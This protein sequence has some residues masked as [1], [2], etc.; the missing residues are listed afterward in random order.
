MVQF[1]HFLKTKFPILLKIKYAIRALIYGTTIP[2]F[3]TN[4]VDHLCVEHNEK[5]AAIEDDL[6][7]TYGRMPL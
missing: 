7:R 4:I 5:T 1:K 6:M 2:Y 3:E